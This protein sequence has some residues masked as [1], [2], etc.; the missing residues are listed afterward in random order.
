MFETIINQYKS[1]PNWQIGIEIITFIFG[2]LS[3]YL[4]KKENILVY[5]TGMI[6]TILTVYIMFH[7]NYYADMS[8][9]I[10]YSIMS[11]YGWFQ[12][13]KITNGEVLSI[14]RTS[15]KEK[16]IGII[17]FTLTAIICIFIYTLFSYKL[18]LNNYLDV[19][20]TSLFFTAMWYMAK[21][22]I[23]NWTLWIVG[24]TIA[25]YIFFDRQLY[26]IAIQ[27]IIFTILA[28]SAYI[29]WKKYLAK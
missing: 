1:I 6:C 15:M 24:N 20:T 22:K 10:Y 17:L 29:E 9:N 19:F 23:E 25:V 11:I 14:S 12:W 28:I 8:I 27:Y 26:I 7:A 4:A 21:K 16:I 2:V 3:V 5:P 13:K 18:Q